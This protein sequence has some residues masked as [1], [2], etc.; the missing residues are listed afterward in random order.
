VVATAHEVDLTPSPG[1]APAAPAVLGPPRL[2]VIIPVWSLTEELARMAERTVR[3]V[4]EVASLATEVIVIDNG[5]PHPAELDADRVIALDENR[6]VGPA[7]NLG[8]SVAA[9]PLL[10]FLNSDCTVEPG[11]DRALV[12]AAT[13]G[14]RIAFPYTDH[15]DG[16]GPRRPDQAGTAGWC[17]VID[18][19]LFAEIGGFDER[20]AP[21]YF[22]DTDYWHRAWDM[23][24]DL[25]PVPAAVV[26][27]E[28][29]TTGRLAEGFEEI[30]VAHRRRY[31]AKHH[32]GHDAVPPFHTRE[33]VDY[34]PP[35]RHRLARLRP[36]ASTGPDRPRVFGL[37][38]A[39]TGTSSLHAA[40]AHLGYRAVHHGPPEM[41]RA[42][43]DARSEG[44]PMLSAVDPELDAFCDIEDVN[45]G[46]AALD[47]DYPGSKFILT[48]RDVESWVASRIRHVEHNRALRDAGRPH[49][50]FLDVDVDGWLAEREAH[51]A[52]VLAHFAGRPDDLLVIDLCAGQGWERLAPFL[53]WERIPERPFPWE[54]RGGAPEDRDAGRTASGAGEHR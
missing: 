18:R 43:A 27:H 13:D 53:G 2:S 8:A 17:F 42:I 16:Q 7:W 22:E 45:R 1:A 21:A 48:V 29:R 20:F 33:V 30:F 39:K 24:V 40:M 35:G 6:G 51:H 5:S 38:L 37:G 9:A 34:P 3:R 28:R 50:D 26:H 19:A 47:R 12:H 46:Y 14:R 15:G 23:G 4:R 32:L 52:E 49:G 44:R 36:W 11:W 54:N 25:N 10:C 41:R 31:E